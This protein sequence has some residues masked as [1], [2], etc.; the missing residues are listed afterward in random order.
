MLATRT[1]D[2][3]P[4]SGT[5]GGSRPASP[6]GPLLPRPNKAPDPL[7]TPASL[8]RRLAALLYDTF[9]L[10]GVLFAAT[11][12]AVV[13]RGGIAFA[14]GD[15]RFTSYLLLVCA[16]FYGWFWT[17]GGQTLGMRAWQIRLIAADGTAVGW[18]RA[19]LRWS[20]AWLAGLCLGLG[21]IW[22]WIDPERCC[23]HDRL[24]GTRIIQE[25]KAEMER[26]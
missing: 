24:S 9:L 4:R 26:E 15:L 5:P 6:K 20:A 12:L 18:S 16:G 21:Y 25:E 11:L 1:T 10:A 19:I 17:H 14:P 8:A 2:R 22:I 7:L 3:S 23:W 13:S